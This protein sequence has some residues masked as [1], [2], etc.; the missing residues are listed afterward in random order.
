MDSNT[1]D[2]YKCTAVNDSANGISYTWKILGEETETETKAITYTK[3]TLT[4]AQKAQARENIGAATIDD[5]KVGADAW[6]SK[7]TVDKLCPSFTES[8]AVVA[9]EPV[10]GYPLEVVSKIAPKQDGTGDPSPNNVRPIS[11]H[12]AVK[13]KRGGKNLMTYDTVDT[14]STTLRKTL[15]SGNLQPPYV[16]SGDFSQYTEGNNAG[17]IN[18]SFDDGTELPVSVLQ[19]RTGYTNTK[20][21]TRIR[22]VHW[23]TGSGIAKLQLEVGSVATAYEPYNC[24]TF[25]FDLGQTVYGG[26][27]NWS[28]GLLTIGWGKWRMDS[29]ANWVD[30]SGDTDE[31]YPI[32][33]NCEA[34]N[35]P[36][37]NTALCTHFA[38]GTADGVVGQ[39]W[40]N[41]AVSYSGRFMVPTTITTTIAGWRTYLAENEVALCYE[42]SEPIT[43]QLSAQ[44]I[45]AL[46][47]VNTLY[48]DTG[49]TEVTGK[50]DPV[51]I[52]EKLT[53]AI[54]SLGGNV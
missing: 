34:Y 32:G 1:G 47:G 6:S 39:F 25:T 11:G 40:I 31:I 14:A 37:K 22:Y 43:V 19:M 8:G 41:P 51:A 50:A 26:S 10:E 7:N 44:E 13:L 3:Q 2:I 53:N 16:I 54:L 48:S 17:L 49:D 12:S 46:G 42:L 21:L 24:K 29:N 35:I 38:R 36:L 33:L 52:I 23:D 28:T 30:L 15:W 18:C 5:T 9:C 27:L 45:L 4:E 20:T